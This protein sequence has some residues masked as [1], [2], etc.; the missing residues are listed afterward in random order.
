M[1]AIISWQF[2][3][4]PASLNTCAAASRALNL[5]GCAGLS[6]AVRFLGLACAPAFVCTS[7]FVCGSTL[8]WA[9][10]SAPVGAVL[11]SGLVERALFWEAALVVFFLLAMMHLLREW[12]TN[13]AARPARRPHR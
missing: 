10:A 9:S 2:M 4:W 5:L 11:L 6:A 1:A 13:R 7:T 3:G 8:A 12:V